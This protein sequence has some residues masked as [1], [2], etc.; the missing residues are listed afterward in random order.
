MSDKKTEALIRT[1]REKSEDADDQGIHSLIKTGEDAGSHYYLVVT[2]NR[3]EG[4]DMLNLRYFKY[5]PKHH[6]GT[7]MKNGI[8]MRFDSALPDAIAQALDGVTERTLGF[9]RDEPEIITLDDV[10]E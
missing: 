9:D 7:W 5:I 2:T 6:G 3:Y 10:D 8:N 1:I 4:R